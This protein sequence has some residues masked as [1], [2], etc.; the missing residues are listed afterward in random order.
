MWQ[1]TQIIVRITQNSCQEPKTF[2]LHNQRGFG[3]P[4]VSSTLNVVRAVLNEYENWYSHTINERRVEAHASMV[5]DEYFSHIKYDC[6]F[7]YTDEHDNDNWYSEIDIDTTTKTVTRAF[8]TANWE[9]IDALEYIKSLW[10]E[11][12]CHT[13]WKIWYLKTVDI[14]NGFLDSNED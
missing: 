4:L 9:E 13:D 2:A 11:E 12:F 8:F 6:N 10:C 5:N 14:I 1:R 7:P 3:R